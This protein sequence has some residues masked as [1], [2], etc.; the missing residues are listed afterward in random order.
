NK[1]ICGNIEKKI[2]TFWITNYI[3]NYCISKYDPPCYEIVSELFNEEEAPLLTI[4]DFE[5]IDLANADEYIDQNLV[6]YTNNDLNNNNKKLYYLTKNIII[7]DTNDIQL[8]NLLKPH[9]E[10]DFSLKIRTK[11]TKTLFKYIYAIIETITTKDTLYKL[12]NNLISVVN[13]WKI[14]EI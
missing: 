3:P 5:Y 9:N 6:N 14:K 10:S 1:L 12:I 11:K 2:K 13:K 8:L 4:N 7:N